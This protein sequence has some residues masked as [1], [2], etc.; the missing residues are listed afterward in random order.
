MDELVTFGKR[1]QHEV[2][3]IKSILQPRT[4]RF[5]L[6]RFFGSTFR[7]SFEFVSRY[8]KIYFANVKF[9]QGSRMDLG[10]E[11]SSYDFCF[12]GHEWR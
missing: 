1:E 7:P 6:L 11:T 10:N 3:W 9:E 5:R 2:E 12:E 4:I 8:R